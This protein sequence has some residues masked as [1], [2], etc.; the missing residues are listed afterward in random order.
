MATEPSS[1]YIARPG[2]KPDGA[3]AS[4]GG[5]NALEKFRGL[6]RPAQMAILIGGLLF[7]FYVISSLRGGG[8]ANQGGANVVN[9]GTQAKGNNAD[10]A[11]FSGLETDRPA[12]MQSVFEQ[13]RRDMADLRTKIE[14]D[15]A[16]RDQALQA[17]LG[18]N[19]ELQRQM[20][21]MMGDF[22]TELKNIQIERARDSERLGQLADQQKQLELNSP[23]DGATAQSP[24]VGMRKRAISQI[25]LGGGGGAVEAITRPFGQLGSNAASHLSNSGLPVASPADDAAAK[26]LPFM[27]PLGFVHARL[28]NGVDALVGGATPALARLSGTYKTAMNT[29]VN[30]DGC[31]VLLEFEANL[32]TERATGKPQKMTCV[33]P[34]QGAVTYSLSG[35][36]VDSEDGIIGIPGVLFEGDPSRIGAA[37]LADFTAGIVDIIASN[38]G[39]G[40]GNSTGKVDENGNVTI[41]SQQGKTQAYGAANTMTSTI[42]DYLK[43]RVDR[44]Q[45]FIRLDATRDINFVILSGVEMRKEGDV[46]TSLFD[47]QNDGG[48]PKSS[49]PANLQPAAGGNPNAAPSNGGQR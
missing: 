5:A 34:D 20:Q 22:T 36:A 45:S 39:N 24:G 35:Y 43:A 25:S 26:R 33:Y 23:V 49:L 3:A 13:N 10:Q 4:A 7:V 48:T 12:V 17:A 32:S 6:P 9:M 11:T 37:M 8:Q 47:A 44:I 1:E 42:R 31:F 21:Q 14:G 40:N 28:L 46:W 30:L 15:F 41:T 27:P 16:T 19:Q 38:N 29:T 2:S 18:Q